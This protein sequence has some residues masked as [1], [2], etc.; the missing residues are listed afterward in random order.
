VGKKDKNNLRN[1]QKKQEIK[2]GEPNFIEETEQSTIF[3]SII[4]NS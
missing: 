4:L 3:N 2:I 1:A